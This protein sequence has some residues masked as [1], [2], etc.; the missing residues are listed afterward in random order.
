MELGTYQGRNYASLNQV[1][2]DTDTFLDVDLT[3]LPNQLGKV[4]NV[5]IR[6]EKV[7]VDFKDFNLNDQ[8]MVTPSPKRKI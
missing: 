8:W 7:M 3:S 1:S 5:G 6:E 4:F 2:G